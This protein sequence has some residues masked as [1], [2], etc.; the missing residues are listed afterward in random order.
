MVQDTVVALAD[1]QVAQGGE[2]TDPVRELGTR[3]SREPRLGEHR[4]HHRLRRLDLPGLEQLVGE[5][6]LP[7]HRRAAS[8]WIRENP[9][10]V[11]GSAH[12]RE[13]VRLR[14]VRRDESREPLRHASS[15]GSHGGGGFGFRLGP[16]ALGRRFRLAGA[17]HTRACGAEREHGEC[18]KKRENESSASPR[19]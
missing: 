16:A 14:V 18:G 2:L 17:G 8:V 5:R 9:A 7:A 13:R 12:A 19:T 3:R 10:E 1:A 15:R 11:F 4:L 6:N